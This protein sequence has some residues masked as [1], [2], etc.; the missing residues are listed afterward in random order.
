M[1]SLCLTDLNDYLQTFLPPA[2]RL[3]E[4]LFLSVSNAE[5]LRP[6]EIPMVDLTALMKLAMSDPYL[7]PSFTLKESSSRL[8]SDAD[9]TFLFGAMVTRS[10]LS[11]LKLGSPDSASSEPIPVGPSESLDNAHL[12]QTSV[13]ISSVHVVWSSYGSDVQSPDAIIFMFDPSRAAPW[14]HGE[15]MYSY[16]MKMMIN[17]LE[18]GIIPFEYL[19]EEGKMRYKFWKSLSLQNFRSR[20]KIWIGVED[21]DRV[22]LNKPTRLGL[23]WVWDHDER[24]YSLKE[25]AED[26]SVRTVSEDGDENEEIE[27]DSESEKEDWESEEEGIEADDLEWDFESD[28]E[29][30]EFKEEEI[31][32]EDLDEELDWLTAPNQLWTFDEDY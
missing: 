13:C 25:A 19:S 31:E 20:W 3:T 16:N 2:H 1:I 17:D 26:E 9:L 11:C 4:R 24:D 8:P 29:D 30:W 15:W 27:K 21:R 23:G 12:I 14:M 22:L 6:H 10:A 7:K 5:E 18:Q 32:G 28:E